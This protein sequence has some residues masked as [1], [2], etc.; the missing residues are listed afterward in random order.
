MGSPKPPTKVE[1]EYMKICNKA[2]N[3]KRL[4]PNM[5]NYD[6]EGMLDQGESELKWM[7][8]WYKDALKKGE[9]DWLKN[10]EHTK[11]KRKKK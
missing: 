11:S 1:R 5:I 9:F 2:E 4:N 8:G 3:N 10:N 6:C 7:T